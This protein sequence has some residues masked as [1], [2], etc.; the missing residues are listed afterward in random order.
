[1]RDEKR[2]MERGPKEHPVI[3]MLMM[4]TANAEQK[5]GTL[6]DLASDTN[7][8]THKAA[9]PLQLRCEDITSVIHGVGEMAMKV[10]TKK[11]N[12]RVRVKIPEGKERAHELL[13]YG[14]DRIAIVHQ[15]VTP[16]QLK[17]FFPRSRD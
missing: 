8:I 3:M 2:L 5:I 15:A 4:V 9:R 14:L 16:Q 13:C 10:A 12:L 7:Y 6:I 1:M 11:Y 17:S